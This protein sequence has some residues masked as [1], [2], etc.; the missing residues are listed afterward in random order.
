MSPTALYVKWAG[1]EP[2]RGKKVTVGDDELLNSAESAIDKRE[3]S[4]VAEC[5]KSRPAVFAL[6]GLKE[7]KFRLT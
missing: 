1:V 7:A 6:D 4:S 2:N 3:Q 5:E